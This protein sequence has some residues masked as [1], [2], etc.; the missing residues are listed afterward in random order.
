MKLIKDLG[1]LK[2]KTTSNYKKRYGIYL[3]NCGSKF[4]AQTSSIKNGYTKSC[5]CLQKEIA[6]QAQ[7]KHGL[8]RTPLYRTWAGIIKRTTNPNDSGYENYG[9]RGII[10]CD[11]WKNDFNL[12][13]EWAVS[14][15]YKVGLTID[16]INNDG[17]YEPNNCRWATSLVQAQNTRLLRSSN[18][19]GY[20]GVSWYK[21]YN[22]WIAQISVNYKKINLGYFFTKI[23]AAKAYDNF[24]K[25]NNLS[26]TTN[27]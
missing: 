1:S 19:S 25:E 12:F 23:E 26:H 17:N 13:H 5:G 16:R 11:E 27:F 9:G 24:I 20:R 22:K 14:N 8:S 7:T 15:G 6:R 4:K 10:M 21:S 3:C 18:K 2:P